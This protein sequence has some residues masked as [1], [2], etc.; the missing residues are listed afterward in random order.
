MSAQAA[1]DRSNELSRHL[2]DY[3]FEFFPELIASAQ[4]VT[5][6]D[7]EGREILD[8][9]SGQMCATLGHNHPADHRSR[10]REGVPRSHPSVQWSH[11][12]AGRR[13][14]RRSEPRSCRRMRFRSMMFLS[15][16]GGE[17]TRPPYAWR[18]STPK[19]TRSLALTGSWHGMT[20]GAASI[21]LR[22]RPHRGYGP[23]RCPARW[24]CPPPTAI[25][26]RCKP[27]HATA[28][29]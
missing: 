14:R 20:A 26:V 8:F 13:A 9:T 6:R 29:T 3:G 10:H 12:R 25:A 22:C 23:A 15:T 1:A 4:G 19:S 11:Q 7:V 27:L 17:P 28:A 5:V 18:N 16:G 2:I 21:D 24:P